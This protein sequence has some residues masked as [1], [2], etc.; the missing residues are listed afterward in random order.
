MNGNECVAD[1]LVK[2]NVDTVFTVSA[3]HIYLGLQWM[4]RK[5]IRVINAKLEL[6]AAFMASV[7]SRVKR[8]PGVL[9]VTSGPG[10]IGSVSPIAGA[11]VEGDPLVV[12]STMPPWGGEKTSYMHQLRNE[13]DQMDLVRPITKSQYKIER[14]EQI[15]QKLFQAFSAAKSGKP[16]PVYVELP[17]EVLNEEK[18]PS[19]YK[20]SVVNKIEPKKELVQSVVELLLDSKLPV[21]IAGRGVYLSDAQEEL[22]KVAEILDAPIATTVMAKGLI[23]P[24]HLLYAGVAAGKLGNITS[25]KIIEQ[26]DC[27]LAVGNRFSEIGTGRY[28]LTMNGRLIHVNADNSDIGRAFK[29]DVAIVADAKIFLSTLLQELAK[30]DVR[31]RKG[32]TSKL[33]ELWHAEFKEL[34]KYYTFTSE[35]IQSWEVVKAIRECASKD[36]FIIGDV[37]A[38]RQETFLMPIY[39]PG[40]YITTTSYVSM[41]IA[42]PGAVAASI[43]FPDRQV[44]GI[45]GDGG[46]LMNGLEIATAVEHKST[47]VIVVFNDAS[48]KV[49]KIYGRARFHSDIEALYR[50]PNV[51]FAQIADALGAKGIEVNRR[52]DLYPSLQEA[53]SWKKGPAVVDVKID[54]NGIPIPLQRLYGR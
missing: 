19:D 25:D 43:A 39:E 6:S 47:P 20:L 2:E 9:I 51:N 30:R 28:S 38:H 12:F 44:I 48:Y 4:L 18:T 11:M 50:L 10:L 31:P 16:G 29:P 13:S 37:G 41:G 33:S 5:N 40:T 22:T 36:A 54:P 17:M 32:V 52:Q 26:A 34:D 3:E 21:I 27:I 23:P 46:F 42:V 14:F 45:V 7:Y 35:A 53:I 8:K 1:C 24:S 49:L 15:P